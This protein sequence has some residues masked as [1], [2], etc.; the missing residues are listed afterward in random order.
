LINEARATLNPTRR[1]QLINAAQ[2][3]GLGRDLTMMCL[4]TYGERLFMNNRITGAV[5]SL[6]SELYYPWARDL[7]STK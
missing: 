7:G 2:A 6:P 1:A 5:P 4:V 3:Q